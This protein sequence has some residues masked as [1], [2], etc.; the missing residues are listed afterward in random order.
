MGFRIDTVKQTA[1]QE[2]LR[3]EIAFKGIEGRGKYATFYS[4]PDGRG[5]FTC[6]FKPGGFTL[7]PVANS[8]QFCAPLSMPQ[9]EVRSLAA[10]WMKLQGWGPELDQQNQA[11]QRDMARIVPSED[12]SGDVL[13]VLSPSLTRLLGW[14]EG[15]EVDVQVANNALNIAPV[16]P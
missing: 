5:L 13:L 8:E 15:Q 1:I 2:T 11:V 4:G 9:E 16:K 10:T 6:E 14:E 3:W 7:H 12:G